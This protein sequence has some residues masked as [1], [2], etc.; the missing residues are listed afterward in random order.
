MAKF[1]F[2]VNTG[3]VKSGIEEEI[4][5]DDS[6]FDGVEENS[7][8]YYKIVDKYYDEWLYE[9]VITKWKRIE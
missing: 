6:A 3:Y 2:S 8:E 1:M 9:N 7:S 4:E 5:I